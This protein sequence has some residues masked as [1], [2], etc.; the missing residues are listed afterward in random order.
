[1]N[2]TRTFDLLERYKENFQKDD[3]LCFKQNGSWIKFSS[4]DYIEYSYNFCY[5]LHELGFRGG[6]K[7]VI[8][9]NNRPECNFIDMG[10]AMLGIIHVPVFASLNASEYEY[11]FRH[12]GAKMIIISDN[13]LFKS[14]SL[15]FNSPGFSAS[16][17]TIDEVKGAGSWLE[18]VE[19]GKLCSEQTKK[20]VESIR[21]KIRPEDFATL[22][23]TS[24]TTGKPKGVMLSHR[25]LVSNFISAA[26]VF[27]LKPTD[28]YLSI[29]PL[30]HVGGRLGNYQTQFSGSSI[31]YAENMGSIAVNMME[32]RPD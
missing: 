16:V 8:V 2:V 19:K 15:A 23:Y 21:K 6:D 9:A 30:C 26:G 14:V 11:I 32:I 18:I 31:Y 29:L 27:N 20:D 10:M 12:S 28:K 1:M 13:R 5:G 25:N 17:Y 22:I 4:Q 3:A 24:G 7:I